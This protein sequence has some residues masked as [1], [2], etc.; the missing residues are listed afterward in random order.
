MEFIKIFIITQFIFLCLQFI[1][2]FRLESFQYA[3]LAFGSFFIILFFGL[4]AFILTIDFINPESNLINNSALMGV[5]FAIWYYLT[6]KFTNLIN[7][8]SN[9]VIYY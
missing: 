8:D 2:P 4:F 7:S 1:Q 5:F 6:K 3:E 9:G